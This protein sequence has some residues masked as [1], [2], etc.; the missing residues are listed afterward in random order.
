MENGLCL[1]REREKRIIIKKEKQKP[2]LKAVFLLHLLEYEC[3]RP[4]RATEYG[5]IIIYTKQFNRI[6]TVLRQKSSAL[7]KTKE[8][9][10]VYYPA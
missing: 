8:N 2:T 9:P 3:C 4:L 6:N 1:T 7:I 10:T 5:R